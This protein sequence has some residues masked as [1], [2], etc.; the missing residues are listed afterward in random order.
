MNKN[1]KIEMTIYGKTTAEIT[2]YC[3]YKREKNR[4]NISEYVNATNPLN[5]E[6]NQ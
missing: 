5:E 1:G 6:K 3:N 2:A 4:I